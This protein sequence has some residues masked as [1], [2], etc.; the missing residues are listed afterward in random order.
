MYK[1]FVE[2]RLA[3]DNAVRVALNASPMSWVVSLDVAQYFENINF[4]RLKQKLVALTAARLGHPT[5]TVIDI[6]ISCLMHWSPYDHSGVPQ[7]MFPSSFLGNVFLHSLDEEMIGKGLS[8][9]RYMDDVRIVAKNEAEARR[10][11]QFAITHLRQLGLSINGKKTGLLRPDSQE[12]RAL[13]APPDPELAEIEQIVRRARIDELPGCVARLNLMLASI[14]DAGGSDRTRLRFC[15]GRLTSFRRLRNVPVPEPV[16]YGVK[17]LDLLITLPE[18]TMYICEYFHLNEFTGDTISTLTTLLTGEPRCVYGWQNYHLWFLASEKAVESQ[19]LIARARAIVRQPM[20]SAE[21]AG[22]ALF[23]GAAGDL[24]PLSSLLQEPSVKELSI[25]VRRAF[26]I[27]AQQLP[28]L[29]RGPAL[30]ALV[31]GSA[32]L[33]VLTAYLAKL[34]TPKFVAPARRISLRRLTDEMPDNF[35]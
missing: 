13:L 26:C 7:N 16:G 35:S 20:D 18:E 15:L 30:D 2:Q 19:P 17:L 14:I 22:A 9:Y 8:Y 1:S 5:R 6:L 11:L 21:F 24:E 32:T 25:S 4:E 12:R 34:K 31:Q 33:N 28:L 23:L 29:E 27:A 10:G 3:F